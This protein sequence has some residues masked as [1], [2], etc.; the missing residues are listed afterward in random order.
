MDLRTLS[1]P[2]AGSEENRPAR[3]SGGLHG[4]RVLTPIGNVTDLDGVGRVATAIAECREG[5]LLVTTPGEETVHRVDPTQESPGSETHGGPDR[6]S[7]AISSFDRR[8]ARQVQRQATKQNADTVVVG[9]SHDT[10][11]VR[12]SAVSW[13]VEH[14]D[15]D[16]LV[17]NGQPVPEHPASILLAFAGG[18][19]SGLAT[20]VAGCLARAH[21]AWVDVLHVVE[22][23]SAP[24]ASEHA[25]EY[26]EAAID[27]LSPY[28][29]VDTWILEASDAAAALVEQSS[30]YDLTVLGAPTKGRLE[31]LVFGSTPQKVRSHGDSAVLMVNDGATRQR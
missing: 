5:E 23:P 19:H 21:D 30:Y 9:G 11:L 24:D 28:E 3:I 13:L 15:C 16:V 1:K 10:P 20:D 2:W 22:T 4:K 25:E 18:P 29:S 14:V 12:R 17:C 7:S 31:R 27:R 26:V 8:M 6:D